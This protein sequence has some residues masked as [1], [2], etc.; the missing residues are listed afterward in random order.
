MDISVLGYRSETMLHFLEGEGIFVSSGSACSKG[1]KS[2]TL[3]AMRLDDERVDSALR[4]SLS[5]ETTEN[6]V[7]AAADAIK[8]GIN[9]LERK[10][11]WK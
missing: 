5:A 9:T 1:E 4:F 2:H 6:E 11:I 8:K 3:E 7:K 10:K